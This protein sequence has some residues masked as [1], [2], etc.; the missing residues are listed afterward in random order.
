MSGQWIFIQAQDVWMFRDSKPFSAQQSFVARSQFPPNPQTMQGVIRTHYL[1]SQRVN[2]KDYAAGREKS[3]IYEMVGH[4]GFDNQPPTLGKL[5]II[6]PFIAVHHAREIELLVHAPL[7]L[8]FDAEMQEF[9]TLKPDNHVDFETSR[10]FPNWRPLLQTDGFK[11]VEGW[12]SQKQFTDYLNEQSI[13]G[14]LRNDIFEY[15]DRMGLGMNHQRRSNEQG[16]LYRARFI[17]PH[18]DVGL[19]VYV[20]Q[21]LFEDAGFIRIGGESRSAKFNV[22]ND[23]TIPATKQTRFKVILLTPSYFTGGYQPQDGDWAPWVREGKLVSAVVG[24]PLA[25]SGWD[26]AHNLPK[27]LRHFVPAGSVYYFEGG[28]VSGVPFTETPSNMA[29]FG[30]MG[31]GSFTIGTW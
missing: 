28:Q 13:Q 25:I 12:L 20:N 1:E 21:P 11:P 9:K 14:E 7:D 31:F 15:E 2:W 19:L 3:N 10:P 24:K 5:Q 4:A 6:G 8:L 17:R 30:S 16:L 23:F 29:D 18:D 27:P 22:I 26:I